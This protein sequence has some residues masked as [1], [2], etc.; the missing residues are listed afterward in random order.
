MVVIGG[1]SVGCNRAYHLTKFGVK[2]V[3]LLE[4]RLLT[5]GTSWAAAGLV[6]NLRGTLELAKMTAYGMKLYQEIE[7]LTEQP[8]GYITTGSLL[9]ATNEERQLE[10]ERFL[11]LGET[12]GV[13]VRRID[14][15]ELKELWPPLNT[16]GILSAYYMPND[17][18]VNPMDSLRLEKGFR[19]RPS[20][21]GP[22]DTP[23]EA[24]LGFAV[25]LDKG[26]FIGREALLR[27]KAQGLKRKLVIFTL[28]SPEPLLYHYEPIYRNGERVSYVTHGAYAH[29][30]GRAIGLGCLENPDGITDQWILDGRCEVGWQGRR[31]PAKVHLKAPYDPQ[32]ERVRM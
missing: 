5:S 32:G 22:D 7:K 29:L 30:L 21:M 23:F 10:Y 9:I 13:E 18:V 27:K 26:D 24:G 1:G 2:D 20:D 8:T 17:A 6:I 11:S 16:A 4:R 25:K 14:L 3:V 15:D 12:L 31:Y 19:H 28:E